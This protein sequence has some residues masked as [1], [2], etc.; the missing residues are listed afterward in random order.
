MRK[1]IL[2]LS[3]VFILL[4]AT[5]ANAIVRVSLKEVQRY[6]TTLYLHLKLVNSEE[7][8]ARVQI[9]KSEGMQ[10]RRSYV[11]GNDD[12]DYDI[13]FID[14]DAYCN[15]PSKT[16][17]NSMMVVRNVPLDVTEL[18]LVEV[19]V[20]TSGM[21]GKSK[22]KGAQYYSAFMFR[23]VPIQV[24]RNNDYDPGSCSD[25]LMDASQMSCTRSGNNV[26]VKFRLK[27]NQGNYSYRFSGIHLDGVVFGTDGDK[28]AAKI[29]VAESLAPSRSEMVTMT[30]YNV[31]KTEK[32]LSY[33]KAH[34]DDGIDIDFRNVEIRA[35]AAA[36]SPKKAPKTGKSTKKK[37]KKSK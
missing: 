9:M 16:V 7:K 19:S 37:R 36:S 31:P 25:V 35:P 6:G 24:V 11:I 26:I 15:I 13:R 21:K 32:I 30:I 2:F 34:L 5:E 3:A 23:D 1:T 20:Y 18:K 29:S 17:A 12:V 27:S 22:V 28:Y 4:A 10:D 8:D 33:V 14:G